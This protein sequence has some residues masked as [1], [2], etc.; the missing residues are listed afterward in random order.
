MEVVFRLGVKETEHRVGVG[1]TGD[2]R[3]SPVVTRDRDAGRFA[4]PAR[5]I[6]GRGSR[7]LRGGG[8]SDGA[9]ESE[10]A[11]SL[12]RAK[13]GCEDLHDLKSMHRTD[14]GKGRTERPSRRHGPGL[15]QQQPSLSLLST[16]LDAVAD[17]RATSSTAG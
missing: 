8:G 16:R 12:G 1:L 5:K 7:G 11:K 14:H 6:S 3:Y 10:F 4:G 13:D 9:E 17:G 2:M 15:S